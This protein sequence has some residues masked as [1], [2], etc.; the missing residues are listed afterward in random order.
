MEHAISASMTG[1]GE[2]LTSR[3]R[4]SYDVDVHAWAMQ[5]AELIKLGRFQE[6]DVDN[7][8]DEVE[9]M[10]RRVR[11]EFVSRLS[12]VLAHVLK[13]EHQ[14]QRRSGSWARTIREQ[15]RQLDALLAEAPSLGARLPQMF[16]EAFKQG[17][18]AAL[19]ETGLEDGDIPEVTTLT[20]R[21]AMTRPIVWPEP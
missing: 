11:Q 16:E 4:A 5:Q 3:A 12:L 21:E 10:A 9:D 18:V 1:D 7:L 19:N 6:L 20:Y 17:R 13:W 2:A 15:R 14:P 8:V